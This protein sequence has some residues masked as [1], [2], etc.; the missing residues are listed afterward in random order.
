MRPKN[1]DEPVWAIKH[2]PRR[3]ADT[4]G[5]FVGGDRDELVPIDQ[6]FARG[7]AEAGYSPLDKSSGLRPSERMVANKELGKRLG[8]GATLAQRGQKKYQFEMEVGAE[9]VFAWSLDPVPAARYVRDEALDLRNRLKK[10]L[11][12]PLTVEQI[13]ELLD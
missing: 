1:S 6:W 11:K 8:I 3:G 5:Y 7:I 9:R 13:D 4:F 10:I 2:T 12:I